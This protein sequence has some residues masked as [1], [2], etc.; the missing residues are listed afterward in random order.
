MCIND[1]PQ[2]NGY[3]FTA[4][5]LNMIKILWVTVQSSLV[6]ANVGRE[7]A[8]PTGPPQATDNQADE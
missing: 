5:G 1:K 8:R 3:F 2:T 4:Y 6:E 7:A